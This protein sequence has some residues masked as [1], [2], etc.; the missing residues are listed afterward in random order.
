[1]PR[2]ERPDK[3]VKGEKP[4]RTAYDKALGL[5]ARREHSGRELSRKLG[6][7]GYDRQDT[8][9]AIGRLGEQGYQDDDRFASMLVRNRASHGYGPARIRAELRN[10]GIGEAVARRLLDEAEVD[11][12]ELGR[13]HP[14][15]PLRWPH[16]RLRRTHP[17]GPVPLA[18]RLRGRHST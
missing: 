2:R 16:G 1:M 8:A 17:P 7:G 10:H 13:R 18:S 14:A 4:Q 3:P 11:W 9:E 5:L 15:S 12:Q 6:Q